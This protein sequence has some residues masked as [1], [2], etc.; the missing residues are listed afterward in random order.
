MAFKRLVGVITIRNG[1]VV[2]SKQYKEFHPGGNLRS[3]LE[4]LDRWGADEI[5]ILDISRNS[6]INSSTVKQIKSANISTPLV[7]GGG[8]REL[9]DIKLLLDAGCDRFVVENIMLSNNPVI[10]E[11]AHSIGE[12]ALIGSIPI[13][14]KEGRLFLADLANKKLDYK[15]IEDFLKSIN[16]SPV[17]EFF[18][19]AIETDGKIG[20][21]PLEVY[22]S[23]KRLVDLGDL[24]ETGIIWFGGIDDDKSR[25]LLEWDKT[26]A[27]CFG[28]INNEREIFMPTARKKIRSSMLR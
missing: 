1:I 17:S 20:M 5:I 7:Y 25:K 26:R 27:V 9:N 15:P 12:Q 11:I 23:I 8:I 22:E 13:K 6:H 24:R 10:E 16:R 14:L 21:F 4:N 3:S 19:S 28:N 2:K 18:I